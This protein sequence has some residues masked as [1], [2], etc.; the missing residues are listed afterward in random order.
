MTIRRKQFEKQPSE[1]YPIDV[2]FEPSKPLG[3]AQL[4]SASAVVI[5]WPRR[6]PEEISDATNEVLQSSEAI[7]IAPHYLKARFFLKNGIH[8]YDYKLT[9]IGVFDN[10]AKLEEDLSIR[11]RNL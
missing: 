7:L 9:V 6:R 2:N 10:G 1:E 11:I 4:V 5:K 8:N 3:S